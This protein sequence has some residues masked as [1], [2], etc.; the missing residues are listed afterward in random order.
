MEKKMHKSK[1]IVAAASAT[2]LTALLG[3]RAGAAVGIDGLKDA[4][5]GAA[6]AVQTNNTSF[7]DSTVGDG[8]SA[9]GSELDAAYGV[10]QNGS[11]YLL[12][13]GNLE[14]NF[15]HINIFIADGRSGQT[16]INAGGALGGMN[17]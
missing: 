14:T 12:F 15:N 5:Y 17:G 9:A 3:A 11:L 2:A 8:T 1:W 7:G 6:R 10:V 13:T 4:D 16:T